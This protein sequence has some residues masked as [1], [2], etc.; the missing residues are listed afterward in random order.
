M[1]QSLCGVKL[2]SSMQKS[3]IVKNDTV[4]WFQLQGEF[5]FL[6]FCDFSEGLIG[7]VKVVESGSFDSEGSFE[8]GCVEDVVDVSVL[9]DA[10]EGVLKAAV[11]V[12]LE[13]VEVLRVFCEN[14]EGGWVFDLELSRNVEAIDEFRLAAIFDLKF[15]AMQKLQAWWAFKVKEILVEG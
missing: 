3:A 4:S 1:P 7:G 2:F 11:L 12:F 13:V 10:D 8:G 9:I 15:Q 5:V 14:L 6:P